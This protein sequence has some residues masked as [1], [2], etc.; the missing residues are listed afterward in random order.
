MVNLPLQGF[1]PTKPSPGAAGAAPGR[2][3]WHVQLQQQPQDLRLQRRRS[4]LC[5]ILDVRCVGVVWQQRR[6]QLAAQPVAQHNLH[7]ARAQ[8]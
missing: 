5:G 6:L 1:I 4:M 3:I 8:A 7:W 2:I